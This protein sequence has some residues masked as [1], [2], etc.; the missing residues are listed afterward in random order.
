M[1][2]TTEARAINRGG[3]RPCR[4]LLVLVCCL[5]GLA[6]GQPQVASIRCEERG[7]PAVVRADDVT[8]AVIVVNEVNGDPTIVTSLDGSQ[9]EPLPRN[10][11]V[12]AENDRLVWQG[13][14][15]PVPGSG[16]L[17]DPTVVW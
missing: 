1:L 17:P 15:L 10:G 7:E 13:A 2:G 4:C 5:G 9:P 12:A 14:S 16:R 6:Y 8:D 11:R 3:R